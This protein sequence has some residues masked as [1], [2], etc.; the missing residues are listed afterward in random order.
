MEWVKA[1]AARDGCTHG[2]TTFL[3]YEKVTGLQ[4]SGC[5]EGTTVIH[6]R[7]TG[8]VHVWP[9]A[10]GERR[11]PHVDMLVDATP[12]IWEFFKQYSLPLKG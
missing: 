11:L 1:W 6:Y 9:G 10:V 12:L 2:P 3:S 4:W 5:Q 8:G 7:L